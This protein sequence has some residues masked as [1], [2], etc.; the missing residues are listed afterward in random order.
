MLSIGVTYK[1]GTSLLRGIRLNSKGFISIGVR[2]GVHLSPRTGEAM[3]MTEL[4]DMLQFGGADTPPRPFIDD[5]MRERS[6]EIAEAVKSSMVLRFKGL[7][8]DVQYD[9]AANDVAYIVRKFVQDGDYY[10]KNVPNSPATIEAKGS[11]IPLIDT[12]QLVQHIEARYV[13]T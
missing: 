2:G 9:F 1:K 7:T 5:A 4:A 8:A 12:G 3:S 10:S 11:E 6:E 13:R